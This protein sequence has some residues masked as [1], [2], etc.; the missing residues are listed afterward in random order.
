MEKRGATG[1][2]DSNGSNKE[3]KQQPP[4]KDPAEKSEKQL[5]RE[6]KKA[7]KKA[8]KET[9]KAGN[10][11]GIERNEDMEAG[12]DSGPDIS[13]GRYGVNKM[14]QSREKL[15]RTLVDVGSLLPSMADKDVWVRARLHTSRAKG[16]DGQSVEFRSNLSEFFPF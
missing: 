5:K 3:N 16:E 4:V 15:N 7:D 6:A 1:S 14:N 9:H 10:A 13:E 2:S 12:T 11:V 8:K